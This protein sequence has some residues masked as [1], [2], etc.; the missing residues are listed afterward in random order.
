MQWFMFWHDRWL[1]GD[2]RRDFT[3]DE[4]SMFIDLLCLCSRYGFRDGAIRTAVGKPLTKQRIC[5]ITNQPLE[6]LERT[7]AK[8]Q[9]SINTGD[10]IG[11]I[12]IWDDGTIYI[13]KFVEMNNYTKSKKNK[14]SASDEA[15]LNS[16]LLRNPMLA[17]KVEQRIKTKIEYDNIAESKKEEIDKINNEL[18]E[19]IDKATKQTEGDNV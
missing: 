10:K 17:S 1:E 12:E 8:G 7:L 4:R 14:A 19:L 9:I 11:R 18:G 16:I 3:N 15:I 5:E 13:P 2:I 6:L